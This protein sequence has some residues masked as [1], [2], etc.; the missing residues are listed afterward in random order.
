MLNLIQHLTKSR[1]Y[2]TL[3]RVQGD[4][5]GLFTIPSIR[6]F[7]F[8]SKISKKYLTN[9]WRGGIKLKKFNIIVLVFTKS[10]GKGGDGKRSWIGIYL[11]ILL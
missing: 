2:Q 4:T 8:F 11:Y 9:F 5:L 10:M 6:D 3:K 7:C 1:T